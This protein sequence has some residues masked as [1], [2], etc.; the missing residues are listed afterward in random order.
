[1]ANSHTDKQAGPENQLL[2]ELE[3][4]LRQEAAERERNLQAEAETAKEKLRETNE[5]L[6]LALTSAHMVVWDLDLTTDQVIFSDNAAELF[7]ATTGST[8]AFINRIHPEDQAAVR[9]AFETAIAGSGPYHSEYRIIL[10]DGQLRW[11]S[12]Q[13]RIHFSPD[14]QPLRLIG[15]STDI[16]HRKETEEALRRERE[17]LQKIF[18]RIPVMI[19]MYEPNTK[20]TRLNREFERLTGWSTEAA[21]QVDLMEKCYP[22]P[23]YR[24]MVRAYM[25]SLQEGWRDLE[26]TTKNGQILESSWSNIWLSDDTHIGIGI[27][28]RERKRAERAVAA[29]ER[30]YRAIFELAGSGKAQTDP[31]TGRFIRVN[32]RFCEITGY[33]R[34]ELLTLTFSDI[35]HPDDRQ[36]DLE[37]IGPVLRGE[38]DHWQL[39]KRY[40]R[41][42]GQV[43]W[44][45]VT[46]SLI[47]DEQGQPLHTIATIQDFT[48]RKQAEGAAYP[49]SAPDL[50]RAG[51][52]EPDRE[53]DQASPPGPGADR[54]QGRP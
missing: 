50:V 54:D 43:A 18:D 33:A 30:E 45:L 13:G 16:T 41:K 53:C 38:K 21:R 11:L 24:E 32:Q 49:Q 22:D 36:R 10:P 52:Q 15:V 29:S 39:E 20:V 46:G 23:R 34:E 6:Q 35:T 3:A 26:L 27:D 42:D 31:V 48:A 7:G 37:L 40:R 9:Q 14:G 19:V 28:I 44:V 5:R 47:R 17:L 8:A 51:L 4:R 25:E 2:A 1:V 12:S